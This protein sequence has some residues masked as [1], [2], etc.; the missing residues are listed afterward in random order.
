PP[1][2]SPA[3][4]TCSRASS[5]KRAW[6]RR[7]VAAKGDVRAASERIER[8]IER[9]GEGDVVAAAVEFEEALRLAPEH[10]RAK[11]YLGWVKDVLNGKRNHTKKKERDEDAVRAV[12]EAL[13]IGEEPTLEGR[14]DPVP[15]KPTLSE[16]TPPP[17]ATVPNIPYDDPPP[18]IPPSGT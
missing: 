17:G 13:D 18:A 3:R 14:W 12:A 9:Y 1:R 5:P 10:A 4:S 11:Q 8:G 16:R 2:R 6:A 7:E 15:L